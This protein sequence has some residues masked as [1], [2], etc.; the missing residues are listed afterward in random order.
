MVR[1][2]RIKPLVSRFTVPHLPTA[3]DA[4]VAINQCV[5][6]LFGIITIT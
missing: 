6:T 3:D 1:C 2:G 5:G 4:P